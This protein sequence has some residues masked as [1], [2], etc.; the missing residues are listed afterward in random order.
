MKKRRKRERWL[1]VRPGSR[2]RKGSRLLIV[3]EVRTMDARRILPD[4]PLPEGPRLPTSM[5]TEQVATIAGVHR[6]TV[7]RWIRS[8]L[9]DSWWSQRGHRWMV[10]RRDW[11]AM[12][13]PI[14]SENYKEHRRRRARAAGRTGSSRSSAGRTRAARSVRS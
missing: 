9:L 7:L 4:M 2:A 11:H 12:L 6:A 5:T 13:R 8:G 10:R 3:E 14:L 1:S